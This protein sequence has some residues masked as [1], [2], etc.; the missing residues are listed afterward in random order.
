MSLSS[1]TSQEHLVRHAQERFS[2]LDRLLG[3]HADKPAFKVR[4][5]LNFGH[6][7]AVAEAP[8]IEDCAALLMIHFPIF[9]FVM[10]DDLRFLLF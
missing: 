2:V 3:L 10:F 8:F 1:L 9:A 5:V 4:R 7:D 6:H